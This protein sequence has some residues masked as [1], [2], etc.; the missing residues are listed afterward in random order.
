ML[1]TLP[2][3]MIG[4]LIL[5]FLCVSMVLAQ[6]RMSIL[7]ALVALCALQSALIALVMHYEFENLRLALPILACCIPPLAWSALQ[8]SG[9]G[10]TGLETVHFAPPLLAVLAAV[11][12]P[13]V[14][15]ALIPLLYFGYGGAI[16]IAV[17][18]GGDALPDLRIESGD[19]SGRI[20]RWISIALI[21]SGLCD[22]AIVAAVMSGNTTW[23]PWIVALG[24]SGLLLLMGGLSLSRSLSDLPESASD[25]AEPQR[26]SLPSEEETQIIVRLDALMEE[27]QLYLDPDL[28]LS[29]LARRLGLPAKTLS[30]AINSVS[31]ENV[32]R[33]INARR[34]K[35]ACALL[36]GA[37]SVTDAMLGA[38]FNTKSNFNREFLR[39][40]GKTPRDYRG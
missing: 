36:E 21:A 13:Y 7:S 8:R 38:G 30:T 39:I 33:Y 2:I 4:A 1:P 22:I 3:P 28:T 23:H 18:R 5:G 14:L 15:D 27:A 37:A 9:L 11:F 10:R 26:P 29:R 20:W 35:A 17:S 6:N 31:G 16:L 24:S 40:T 19:A 34:I 25:F 32:S 12:Q